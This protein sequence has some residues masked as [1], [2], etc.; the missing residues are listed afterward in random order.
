MTD[1]REDMIANAN[2]QTEADCARAAESAARRTGQVLVE[3]LILF[4]ADPADYRQLMIDSFDAEVARR[5]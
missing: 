5:A 3:T 4:D 1:N 2:R